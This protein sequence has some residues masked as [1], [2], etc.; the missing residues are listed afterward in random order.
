MAPVLGGVPA[1]IISW[2]GG[3]PF[4]CRSRVSVLDDAGHRPRRG[5]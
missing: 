5:V 2:L 3:H 4:S 1:F